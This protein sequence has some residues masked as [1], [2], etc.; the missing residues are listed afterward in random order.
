M[1]YTWGPYPTH[2]LPMPMDH[3]PTLGS[4]LHWKQLIGYFRDVSPKQVTFTSLD[5]F[6]FRD[7]SPKHVILTSSEYCP[8]AITFLYHYLNCNIIIIFIVGRF[9]VNNSER[10]LLVL[11]WILIWWNSF[12]G[13]FHQEKKKR[14]FSNLFHR[15]PF[16]QVFFRLLNTAEESY[17]KSAIAVLMLSENINPEVSSVL[18]FSKLLG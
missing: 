15:S 8:L 11:D 13:G 16:S 14:H 18:K 6:H 4:R 7:V 3:I 9:T 17:F 12:C 2:E 1:K 5:Y 10:K